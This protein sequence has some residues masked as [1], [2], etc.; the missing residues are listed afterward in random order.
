MGNSFRILSRK[1]LLGNVLGKLTGDT[2]WRNDLGKQHVAIVEAIVDTG[3]F[4][5]AI[6][7]LVIIVEVINA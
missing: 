5:D 2:I 7:A 6:T 3:I 4:V 1:S